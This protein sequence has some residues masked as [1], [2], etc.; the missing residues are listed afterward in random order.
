MKRGAFAIRLSWLRFFSIRDWS[1]SGQRAFAIALA[2]FALIPD[3]WIHPLSVLLPLAE[4]PVA[5]A[6]WF[7]ERKLGACLLLTLCLIFIAALG[8][9]WRMAS[10]WIARASAKNSVPPPPR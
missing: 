1:S 2:P 9:P 7:P 4:S 8:W 3:Y 10:S 5:S 6:S